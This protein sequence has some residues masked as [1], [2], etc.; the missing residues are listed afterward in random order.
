MDVEALS[1]KN[2][3]KSLILVSSVFFRSLTNVFISTIS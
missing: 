2:R 1:I 3:S